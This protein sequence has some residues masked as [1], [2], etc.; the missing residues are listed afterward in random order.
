MANLDKASRELFK[1]KPDEYFQSLDAL[2]EHCRQERE[3]SSDLWRPPQLL[4][5]LVEHGTVSVALET[6]PPARLN[7]WSFSQLCRMA[8]INRET[9]NRLT[10]ETASLALRE[11]LPQAEKPSQ[12]LVANDTV[13]SVHGV[14]YTRLWNAELLDVV[15]D[16]APEFQLP[17]QGY[18]G[19]TGLYCGEQDL[20]CFLID[21]NGWIEIGGQEYAPGFFVWNSEVGRRSL[22]IQTFWY[23][24]ICANHIVWDATEVIEF[25]RKHTANV[26]DGL[27]EIRR[28]IGMLVERRDARRDGFAR[29]IENAQT[30]KLGNDEEEVAKVLA[31]H[32]IPKRL[33]GAAIEVA[34][35]SNPETRYTLAALV[36][37]MTRFS[38]AYTFAGERTEI[39]YRVSSLL[40][41]A[42]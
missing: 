11:T 37:S 40:A 33:A 9:I 27:D 18:N 24:K 7:D 1:R 6:G 8:G 36:D 34:R 42:V 25:T 5:P 4:A 2:H 17:R 23:Q 31:K 28:L 35:I 3:A 20:F 19:A 14:A 10:P 13:R 39:D 26:R 12:I 41:L 22:G 30:L 32:D 16:A 38:Q 29:V 15:R 21:P